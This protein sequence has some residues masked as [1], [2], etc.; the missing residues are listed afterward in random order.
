MDRLTPLS[1][2]FLE[3]EDVDP[4]ASLAIGSLT[5]FEGPAPGFEEFVASIAGRLPLIPRY[6][7]RLQMVPFDLGS[8]VWVD[9]VDFDIHEHVLQLRVPAPGGRAEIAEMFDSVMTWRMDRSRPLWELWL[10]EGLPDG[11]W[12]M[13]SKLHHSLADGVSGTDLFRLTLDPTPDPAR[14]VADEW[15]PRRGPSSLSLALGGVGDLLTSPARL[16]AISARAARTPWALTRGVASSARGLL[17]LSGAAR[18]VQQT[19]LI[20][21]LAGG[22]RYGW[23]QASLS[24][25]RTV[26]ARFGVSFNDVALAA[27]TG[28]FR[29]LLQERGETPHPRALRS[30][31]PVSTRLPG[32]E[33]ELDNRV[34]LLLP[35]LPVEESDP[36]LRLEAIH[37]RVRS[38]RERHEVEA[39]MLLTSS[40][41]LAPFAALALGMRMGFTTHQRQIATV[42]TNV[43]GPREPVY[44]L[45]RRAV[46]MLPYVPIADRVRVGIVMFSYLDTLTFGVT[47]DQDTTADLEVL[48]GGIT[49]AMDELIGLAT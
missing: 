32:T 22:R 23:T 21:E 11:R 4:S 24:D 46:E 42:T 48:T 28:G 34:S 3:A 8:P 38:L 10:I 20:G 43:P 47:G 45:G 12:G 37:D 39:G 49:A 44:C 40:A 25:I 26:R 41:E 14:P 18:P 27:I 31:V 36:V 7:Q 29:T 30:L 6:R 15:T 2:A 1:T 16:G 9:D 13:L 17:A 35:W 5:V 19:S 33:G